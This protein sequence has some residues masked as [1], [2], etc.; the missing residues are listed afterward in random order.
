MKLQRGQIKDVSE[1]VECSIQ[2]I[3]RVL[4]GTRNKESRSGRKILMAVEM[5]KKS[6]KI[7]RK[8]IKEAMEKINQEFDKQK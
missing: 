5:M 3:H 6:R 8:V 2:Q 7:E 4:N 1:I